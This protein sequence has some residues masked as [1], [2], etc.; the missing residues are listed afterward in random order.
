MFLSRAR[1]RGAEQPRTYRLATSVRLPWLL[2]LVL[3][4]VLALA[5]ALFMG[6]VRSSNNNEVPQ[7]VVENQEDITRNAAQSVRRSLNEGVSDLTA[8][9]RIVESSGS[10][11]SLAEPLQ[12]T[13]SVYGRYVG[14]G[15]VNDQGQILAQT[16]AT[17]RP[18]LLDTVAPFKSAGMQDALRVK[19]VNEPIVLQFAPLTPEKGRARAVVGQYDA[20][21]FRFP[22]EAAGEADVWLVNQEG[23]VIGS[24]QGFTAFQGLPE[25][26][27]REA[28]EQAADGLS[29]ALVV[30][31]SLGRQQVV[32]FSP[33]NGV[34]PAGQLGWSVITARSVQSLSLPVQDLRRQGLLASAIL[35]L[36]TIV[37]FGWLWLMVLRPVFRL[38]KEAERVAYGDLSRPVEIIRYDEV[39]LVARSLERIRILLIRR[40]VQGDVQSAPP[41]SGQD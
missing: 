35:G 31:G 39:G 9:S 28:A 10:T 41:S 37:I 25:S 5:L 34:G 3:F 7:I 19:G 29:G 20:S 12:V 4:L 16:G 27:L 30:P 24:R 15:V 11:G 26:Y 40:R 22:L 8:F 36:L 33:V 38:Q 23:R 21:F 18:D 32:A 1:S 17:P 2:G 14:I 6:K 13:A